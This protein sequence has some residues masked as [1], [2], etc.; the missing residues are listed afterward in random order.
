MSFTTGPWEFS[1]DG[2]WAISPWNAR[3]RIATVTFFAPMNAID[4]KANGRLLAA[5]PDL[6]DALKAMVDAHGGLGVSPAMQKA[7]A[8]LSKVD[9]TPRVS[10][11]ESRG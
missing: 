11:E 3:V 9:G 10:S 7:T 2:I 6:Y 8:A 4:E 5:A 1:V